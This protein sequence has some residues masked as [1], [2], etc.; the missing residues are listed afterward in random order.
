[1]ASEVEEETDRQIEA[2]QLDGPPS[3]PDS[4]ESTKS[5]DRSV[6]V[7]VLQVGAFSRSPLTRGAFS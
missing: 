1:M 3:A 7:A 5:A 2:P 4:S 6:A